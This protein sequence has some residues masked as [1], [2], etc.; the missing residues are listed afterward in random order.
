VTHYNA[1]DSIDNLVHAVDIAGAQ[2]YYF[3]WGRVS[4]GAL[5][6]ICEECMEA[7]VLNMRRILDTVEA[8]EL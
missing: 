4:P 5:Y 6:D 2:E 1:G 8:R 7:G 3:A